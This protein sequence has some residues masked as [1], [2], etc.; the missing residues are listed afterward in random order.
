MIDCYRLTNKLINFIASTVVIMNKYFKCLSM[1]YKSLS[2]YTFIK[3]KKKT[4]FIKLLKTRVDIRLKFAKKKCNYVV[5]KIS[6]CL[7]C[8]F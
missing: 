4:K 7:N 2:Q 3:K 5:S 1:S 8:S 6:Y